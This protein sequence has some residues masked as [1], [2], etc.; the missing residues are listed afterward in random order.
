[1]LRV[2]GEILSRNSH[3]PC[4]ASAGNAG[5]HAQHEMRRRSLAVATRADPIHPRWLHQKHDPVSTR[6]TC[7]RNPLIA[8]SIG[9]VRNE[10]R[11]A[12]IFA[13]DA[14]PREWMRVGP[15]V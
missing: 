15:V 4:R 3:S 1:M 12:S 2:L 8:F 9:P 14:P 7:W 13:P 6:E 11:V 10:P 5:H